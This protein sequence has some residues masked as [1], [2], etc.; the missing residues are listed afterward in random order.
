[1]TRIDTPSD[2]THT[3]VQNQR[4]MRPMPAIVRDASSAYICTLAPA[5][6]L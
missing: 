1:M 2:P 4:S 5:A 6:V 3:T